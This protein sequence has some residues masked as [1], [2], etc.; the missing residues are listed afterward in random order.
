MSGRF[1][2]RTCKDDPNR[3]EG[4]GGDVQG[5]REIYKGTELAQQ[6]KF[7]LCSILSKKG[8]DIQK[9]KI[10]KKKSSIPNIQSINH[11]RRKKKKE[12]KEDGYV[13]LV[14]MRGMDIFFFVTRSP[15]FFI[16]YT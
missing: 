8:E 15:F 14:W 3:G 5:E 2:D 9:I 4:C 7:L 6:T 16:T 13:F 10:T 12:R 1:S 11:K